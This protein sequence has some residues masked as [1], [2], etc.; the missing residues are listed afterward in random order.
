MIRINYC[1]LRIFTAWPSYEGPR[2]IGQ[3]VK[4]HLD[5]YKEQLVEAK[6][7]DPFK[8]NCQSGA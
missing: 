4:E 8:I 2:P 3:G 7:L 6:Q 1:V 5:A